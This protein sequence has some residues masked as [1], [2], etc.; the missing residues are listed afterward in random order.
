M[1]FNPTPYKNIVPFNEKR[2]PNLP[3]LTDDRKERILNEFLEN[4]NYKKTDDDGPGY[5]NLIF[6]NNYILRTKTW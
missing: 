5:V 4:L 6:Y 3:V 2:M 1:E